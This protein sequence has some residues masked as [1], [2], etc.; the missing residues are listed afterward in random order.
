MNNKKHIIPK[1][2]GLLHGADYNPEQWLDRPDI[3]AKDIELMK[4][5]NCNVMSVGIFSW[6][7][8]E[9]VEGEFQFEWLDNVLDN[10][11]GNGIS[12]FLAT[13]SG[14]RPAWLSERY[15]DVLRVN[16]ARIKQLHGERHNHCYSSPNYR[17]KV[18][19][20]NAKLAERY[21]QHP[22][23]IGW[24]VSNEYG[25]DCHCNYCQEEFRLW[26]KNKYGSLYNLNKLW[27]SAFWSHTYTS[28]EQIESPSPV[29]ENSVHALKLDWKR[30]CTDRVSNFCEHEIAPLKSI[31]PDLPTTAN[32]MEYFYDYN[33]WELAKSI[34]VV[35]WDSYPLWHRDSDEVAL[36]CY[37]GMYHDLMRTLKNQP[38]LLMES[39]PSQTNWQPITKLKKDGVHL[40]SSL[41]AVAHGSDSVQ[42]FQWRKSR[43]SVEK[44]HGA[45]IDHVGHANTRTGREVTAV[46]E[47]LKQINDVAGT[48]TQ[49]E[50][51]I[52][53]DWE[54]RWAMDDASGPRNEGMHYEQTV[55]DHYRGFWQQG[56]SCDIIEQ[57][58][59]FTPYKIIVAPMLYLIKPG[60]AERLEAFVEQGGTLVATYWSGIVD[61]NDLCF[62]GGFPGGEGSPLRR[63]LG[64]WTEEIDSLYDHERVLFEM[65]TH[66]GFGF[67]GEFK[68]KHLMEHIHLET[69]DALAY[70]REDLFDACPVITKNQLG[71]GCAY[72]I[73]ARTETEFNELFYIS[74]ANLHG[75]RKPIE[76]V[77]YGVSVTTREDEQSRYLFIMNFLNDP[78]DLKVP[79]GNWINASTGDDIQENIKLQ[80][81]Q[82]IVIRN[83][84]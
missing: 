39:T 38:F 29:G 9:P 43:G 59:D 60:V 32:F 80:P 23:V 45:V 21:S 52:I 6:S 49:A 35:S 72:Y 8:L 26:L 15:P 63:T 69:A 53:F 34:D 56:I 51:A 3:L 81:Y 13:P 10:L 44:F 78:R 77:P 36:A 65:E 20:M 41:Q 67:S 12:V 84:K 47:Y 25:G 61:Q 11:A 70:Y 58:C 31:N 5:T 82:V 7:A 30:F 74:L 37:T 1:I 83:Y 18:S 79:H 19:I 62:L 54:N 68:A 42:Y 28:W 22:A 50:V 76:N 33:Y 46:G 2:K 17:E 57:L 73:A 16:S 24:H 71:K 40:L 14:A 27:W 48:N 66:S 75:I 4:Q 64:I 55:C